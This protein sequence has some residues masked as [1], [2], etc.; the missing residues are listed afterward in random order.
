MLHEADK[1]QKNTQ[2]P[3][4]WAT[5]CR[6]TLSCPRTRQGIHTL[7]L[8]RARTRTRTRTRTIMQTRISPRTSP[9]ATGRKATQKGNVSGCNIMPEDKP[10]MGQSRSSGQGQG[11]NRYRID[12][13]WIPEVTGIKV[14]IVNSRTVKGR[15]TKV[16]GQ[17][18][19]GRMRRR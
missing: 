6:F 11:L 16:A 12:K 2:C 14:A 19:G 4:K 7:A 1:G 10:R 15:A 8:A 17:S 18:R 9:R 3:R 13:V 5:V